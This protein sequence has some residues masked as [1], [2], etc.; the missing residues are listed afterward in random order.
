MSCRVGSTCIL[1]TSHQQWLGTEYQKQTH[2]TNDEGY[3]IY[4]ISYWYSSLI[5]IIYL[6][7]YS[8]YPVKFTTTVYAYYES[9]NKYH[10]SLYH[11]LWHV[12]TLSRTGFEPAQRGHMC[13]SARRSNHSATGQG[14][15]VIFIFYYSFF[16]HGKISDGVQLKQQ[17][18]GINLLL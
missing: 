8:R 17:H 16:F 5:F 6:Y 15:I 13:S 12:M 3:K 2:P 14:H 4:I 9:S 7:S 18:V 10:R 11:D 1:R